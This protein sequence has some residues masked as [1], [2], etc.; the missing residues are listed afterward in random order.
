[1]TPA[2]SELI[3]LCL[4]NNDAECFGEL[5][6]R[7]QSAVRRFLRHLTHG[8]EALADDWAQETFSRAHRGLARFRSDS[9]FETWLLGIA[10]N[11]FRNSRRLTAAR[12]PSRK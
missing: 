2:D 1:L 11:Q 8:N 3:A 10:N 12:H 9:R 4:L 5:V 7:H 6:Q